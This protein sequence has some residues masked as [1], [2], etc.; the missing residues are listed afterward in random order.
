MN[1]N[2]DLLQGP[3]RSVLVQMT[4]PMMFGIVSIM[5]FNLADIWFVGQLGTLPM[6]ALAFTFPV[7]FAVVSLAIGLGIGTSATLARRIG[8][9]NSDSAAQLATSI[10]LI[11]LI[12][13]LLVGLGGQWL[14]QPVF[15]L[16]GADEALMPL[17]TAY[18]QI[19]FA[20]SVFM[21]M[22]MVC[23]SILRATGDVRGSAMIMLLASLLNLL[24]DPVF[25]FGLGPVP[26]LGIQGAAIASVLAWSITTLVALHL[27]HHRRHLLTR[28]LPGIAQLIG[29]WRELFAI[30][31]PAA[32]SN[33]TTPVANGV[34]TAIVARHGPEA[35]AAFGVGNRIESLALLVCLALSMSL[36]PFISQNFGA[37]QLER[38]KKAYALVIR[39][40]IIWQL[41]IYALLV[42]VSGPVAAFFS[43]DPEVVYWIRIWIMIVPLGF[44]FQAT[45][46]LSASSFNA[47][48]Q[49]LTALKISL[50]R[51]FIMYL[52]LGWLG[53]LLFGLPGLFTALVMANVLTAMIAWVWMRKNLTGLLGVKQV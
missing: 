49:P 22:N 33:I 3:M 51:L 31:L 4:V 42:L 6:A 18:M 5:L 45:T 16:L 13:L 9:G 1:R 43:D 29:Y 40:A 38:V 36:P 37:G 2:P 32:L 35:V 39:F 25:I 19:W 44:A 15:S 46:F 14:I 7:S 23:N 41:L 20:G 50:I 8:E 11:T 53:N 48:H 24:L 26:A 52:P 27:I 28:K 12:L 30:S 34:L 47:L 21:V 10:L 17:I